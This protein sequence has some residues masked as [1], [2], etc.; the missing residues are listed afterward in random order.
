MTLTKYRNKVNQLLAKKRSVEDRLEIEKTSLEK[1]EQ[2]GI[3][4]QAAQE[5]AQHTAQAIQ[6][7]AHQKISS[8]VTRCQEAVFDNPYDFVIK[9][10]RKRGKTE[11][12]LTMVRD[13]KE[14]TD[15]KNEV[16]GGPVDIASLALRLACV[17]LS[18]PKRRRLLVLDEPFRNVRGKENKQRLRRLLLELAE[19]LDFQFILNVDADAYPEFALGTIIELGG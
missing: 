1:C 4:V 11:A 3:D 18:K 12:Q 6:Q 10:E 19:E 7:Q 5:I 17:V 13:G 14:F 15:P 16:G 2:E 8:L 9:F